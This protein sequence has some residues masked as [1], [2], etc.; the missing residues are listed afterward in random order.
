[1]EEKEEVIASAPRKA[2]RAKART[3]ISEDAQ[4]TDKDKQAAKESGM[5]DEVFRGE[6]SKFRN[7]HIAK[8][9]TMANWEAA[10]RT[11]CANYITFQSRNV[12]PFGPAGDTRSLRERGLAW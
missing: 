8:G 11:W 1:M 10:W 4:P 5:T 2:S 12:L 9:S 7:H 6:W 3:K